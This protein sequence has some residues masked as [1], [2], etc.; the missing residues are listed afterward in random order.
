MDRL[1]G[2]LLD[3][4]RMEAGRFS[5]EPRPESLRSLIVEVREL[6]GAIAMSK[7]V[8]LHA[9]APDED[10]HVQADRGRVLQ[11]L[12][13]LIGNA[14][15]FTPDGGTVTV[16]THGTGDDVQFTIADTGTGIDKANLPHI[17]DRFWH[18]GESGG[19]GLGLAIAQGIVEA[20]HGRIWVESG[21]GGTS[22]HFTLP[23]AD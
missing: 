5:V 15:K 23:A 21:P 7:G 12:S 19:A 22:F 4:S 18:S 13:N 14:I 3:V 17:F 2:D 1:I 16:S 11:V 10:V 20:H 9:D 6:F 8:R